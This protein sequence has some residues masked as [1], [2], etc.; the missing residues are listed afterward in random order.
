L[1]HNESLCSPYKN[2]LVAVQVF[3]PFKS[4]YYRG[5]SQNW[6]TYFAL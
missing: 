1:A 3:N 2:G 6:Q 5:N 4:V